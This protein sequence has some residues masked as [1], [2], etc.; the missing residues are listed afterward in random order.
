M[1]QLSYS[2][3]SA[4]SRSEQL[5]PGALVTA[6]AVEGCVTLRMPKRLSVV[7]QVTKRVDESPEDA[8]LKITKTSKRFRFEAIERTLLIPLFQ[9]R[10]LVTS[11]AFEVTRTL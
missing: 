4:R 3:A 6:R 8:A 5:L 9:K 11:L 10:S 1:S 2:V 7:A